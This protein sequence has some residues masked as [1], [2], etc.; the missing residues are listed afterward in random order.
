MLVCFSLS[1]SSV[2]RQYVTLDYLFRIKIIR[3]E[4]ERFSADLAKGRVALMQTAK[5]NNFRNC[6]IPTDIQNVCVETIKN[7]IPRRMCR[8]E[9]LSQDCA[10][11]R[12]LHAYNKTADIEKIVSVGVRSEDAHSTR[13]G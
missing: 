10:L 12:E 6:S 13:T 1:A 11:L 4:L 5:N 3:A 7:D 9:E 8:F 2:C